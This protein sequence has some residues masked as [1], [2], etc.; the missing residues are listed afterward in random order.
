MNKVFSSKL[1]SSQYSCVDL[2]TSL[3]LRNLF[4]ILLVTLIILSCFPLNNGLFQAAKFFVAAILLLLVFYASKQSAYLFVPKTQVFDNILD[5]SQ[6][7]V[8][9][10]NN[11]KQTLIK[12]NEVLASTLG[13]DVRQLQGLS[14]A[15]LLNGGDHKDHQLMMENFLN[16]NIAFY[17]KMLYC[18]NAANNDNKY[19]NVH[20]HKMNP[21]TSVGIVF[22]CTATNATETAYTES[23]IQLK[24]VNAQLNKEAS[25]KMDF[26]S[27]LGHELRNPLAALTNAV[28][29]F[30]LNQARDQID[31][32]AIKIMANQTEQMVYLIDDIIS[33]ARS[34]GPGYE[35][36]KEHISIA[37]V[38]ER[39]IQLAQPFIDS[40]NH[41][42]TVRFDNM[43]CTTI[44]G[45][46]I[47]LIQ[48]VSNLLTNSAKYTNPNGLIEIYYTCKDQKLII[49]IKDNGMGIEPDQLTS[50]FDLCIRTKRASLHT[51]GLGVG[52]AL[53]KSIVEKHKGTIVAESEGVN[54]GSLFRVTLP[55]E[56]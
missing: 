20:I 18:K 28:R 56:V 23:I 53:V 42:L 24:E 6:I 46:K 51:S 17:N 7:G 22:D 11:K 32:T 34:L 54:T 9:Y 1:L 44:F 3:S 37:E 16:G 45:D 41:Q 50:I 43:S 15:S 21:T 52:L 25:R 19:L 8:F 2:Q 30:N 40:H 4:Y 13:L 47:R 26:L 39:S 5:S 48:V 31:S 12:G 55:L 49:E 27:M 10:L 36:K 38:I 14:L 35:L 29:L 33:V